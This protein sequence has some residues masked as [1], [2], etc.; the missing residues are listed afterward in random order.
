M[1]NAAA[2]LYRIYELPWSTGFDDDLKFKQLARGSL[3]AAVVFALLFWVLP[4]PKIDP[5]DVPEIPKT[6]VRLVLEQNV[7][8]RV[9]LDKLRSRNGAG[10]Q[11]PLLDRYRLVGARVQHERWR[12]HLTE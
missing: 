3:I 1:A 6:L 4:Q 12:A 9:E 11:A 8:G 10:H 5:K 2:V 7:I